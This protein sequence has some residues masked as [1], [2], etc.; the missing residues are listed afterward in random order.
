MSCQICLEDFND[1]LAKIPGIERIR[2][3]CGDS[4]KCAIDVCSRCLFLH[5]QTTLD[6][7]I[8]GMLPRVRCPICL[9]PINKSQWI[10]YIP[11]L[12]AEYGLLASSA[13]QLMTPCCHDTTY[14]H[15]PDCDPCVIAGSTPVV[16]NLSSAWIGAPPAAQSLM[17]DFL[18]HRIAASR[19]IAFIVEGQGIHDPEEVIESVMEHIYDDERRA[20]LYLSYLHQFPST[21][22][23]CCERGFCFNC[24][25]VECGEECDASD[26]FDEAT[27]MVRCRQCRVML[28][29]TEGC[30]SVDCLCGFQMSWVN[31]IKYRDL[32]ARGLISVDLL[33][34]QLMETW[35][36]KHRMLDTQLKAQYDT[37]RLKQLT[38]LINDHRSTLER[39]VGMRKR[40]GSR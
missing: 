14:S 38:R 33:D 39:F 8:N 36:A 12:E 10:R 30:N 32:Y 26:G 27:C 34:L 13:L 11:H 2:D 15:L 29:V 25:G 24:K 1:L 3:L 19:V 31:E 20:A 21:E 9:V 4:S 40:A 28:V 6:D 23:R 7:C 18:N 17:D 22:T 37:F 16:F 5:I 35:E